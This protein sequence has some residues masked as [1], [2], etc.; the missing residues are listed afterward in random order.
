MVDSSARNLDHIF[1]ALS[2]PTRRSILKKVSKQEKAV[3]EIAE[4]YSMSLAAI[5][6]HIQ[7]LE[8]AGLVSRRKEGSYS[9][10]S[11]N[12]GALTSVD[13]WME[14]YRAFWEGSL[15]SLK[16]FIEKEEQ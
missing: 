2:D 14:Y 16:N 10:L 1:Q 3:G 6:K 9:Y 5:S 8:R 4:S 11:L 15:S 7:S 13:K 12:P